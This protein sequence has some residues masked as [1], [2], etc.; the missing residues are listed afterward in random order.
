MDFWIGFF[1]GAIVGILVFTV[2]AINIAG[3]ID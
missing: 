3:D 2:I 1:T